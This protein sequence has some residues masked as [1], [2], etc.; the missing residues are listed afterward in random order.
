MLPVEFPEQ[1]T[2]FARNQPEY[3]PLPAYADGT[4]VI[5]CWAM[6]FK[7]RLRVLFSGAIWVRQLTFGR[8]LQPQKLQTRSP[9]ILDR[10]ASTDD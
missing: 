3:L 2:L 9:F 10:K 5:S 6:T 4:E 8:K 1:T 7:E